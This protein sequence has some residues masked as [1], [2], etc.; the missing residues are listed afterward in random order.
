MEGASQHLGSHGKNHA[1]IEWLAKQ[2][3]IK[4]GQACDVKS[5]NALCAATVEAQCGCD[6]G[7]IEAQLNASLAKQ[8][9]V[10][11]TNTNSS[12]EVTPNLQDGIRRSAGLGPNATSSR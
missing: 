6:K 10:K 7:C 1:A 5:Y 11:H 9:T 12:A 2:K 3:G 4:A 8:K